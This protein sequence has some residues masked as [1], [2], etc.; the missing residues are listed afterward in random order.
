M[1]FFVGPMVLFVC[2]TCTLGHKLENPI[3]FFNFNKK[4][5]FLKLEQGD[6][7]STRVSYLAIPLTTLAKLL[8]ERKMIESRNVLNV[9]QGVFGTLKSS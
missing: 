7:D 9:K 8:R 6:S 2:L 3:I 4:W 1:S 5:S